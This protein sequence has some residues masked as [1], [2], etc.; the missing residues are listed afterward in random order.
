MNYFRHFGI[1]HL[2][3]SSLNLYAA[4]PAL[5]VMERLLGIKSGGSAAMARGKAAEVGVHLGLSQPYLSVE[6]CIAQAEREYDR[7]MA[8]VPDPNR[9]DERKN[10]AGY[11]T[12]GIQELRQYGIPT[13][14]QDKVSIKLEGVPVPVIGFIDW[15][16]D[17]HGLIVDLKTSER[18]PSGISEPHGRQ[19]A[20]Y[21]NAHGNYDMRFAYVKPSPGKKD[22]RAAVIYGMSGDDR[23]RHLDALRQIALRL[24]R[25]LSL[26][27]DPKELAGLV[28]PNYESF[29]WSNPQTRKNGKDT[30]G[31]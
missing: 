10:I 17:Q 18:L 13:S 27:R 7:E 8:L 1:E 20:I 22:G 3:A 29:Y 4:E 2:S 24:H 15:R 30:F 19:G 21:A 5:W 16:F 6:A 31:F 11:V 28:C 23:T 26:S 9:E 12:N 14:Y 25:F